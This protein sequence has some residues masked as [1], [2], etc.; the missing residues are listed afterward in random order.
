[1]TVVSWVG[2]IVS[3]TL[4][5]S[6]VLNAI[7]LAGIILSLNVSGMSRITLRYRSSVSR[8]SE[9]VLKSEITSFGF[10]PSSNGSSR[11]PQNVILHWRVL[12]LDVC[13]LTSSMNPSLVG[14]KQKT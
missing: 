9:E 7:G 5:S 10:P 11:P 12:I 1:M 2:W 6:S 14:R 8:L 13:S 4:R 3:G